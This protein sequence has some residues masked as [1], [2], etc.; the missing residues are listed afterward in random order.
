MEQNYKNRKLANRY[1]LFRLLVVLLLCVS[2]AAAAGCSRE[3]EVQKESYREDGF[4]GYSNS[5]PNTIN[6]YSTM[7]YQESIDFVHE[8]LAPMSGIKKQDLKFV[9]SKIFLK[10]HVDNKMSE[11]NKVKL[12]TDTQSKLQWNFPEYDVHVSVENAR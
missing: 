6:R 5:N 12:Q 8:L 2:L 7:S 4:K 9:G 10:L 3:S 11:A 1:G